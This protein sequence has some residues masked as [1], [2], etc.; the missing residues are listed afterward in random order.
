MTMQQR[1]ETLTLKVADSIINH[2]REN[3]FADEP[4]NK[5]VGL[6]ERGQPH[7]ALEELCTATLEDGLSLATFAD[8]ANRKVSAVALNGVL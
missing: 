6:C 8:E 7:A 3:F 5:A 4:L 1:C 2:L